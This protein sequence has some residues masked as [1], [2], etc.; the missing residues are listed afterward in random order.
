MERER[1]KEEPASKESEQSV[2]QRKKR[3][4]LVEEIRMFTKPTSRIRSMSCHRY[5]HSHSHTLHATPRTVHVFL[6]LRSQL[7]SLIH[8]HL[9]WHPSS[10]CC[11]APPSPRSSRLLCFSSPPAAS[12][13]SSE[14]TQLVALVVP[15][16]GKALA[17]RHRRRHC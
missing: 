12:S 9:R 6:L 15:L 1:D 14:L 7:G 11:S 5:P 3:S 4:E 16:L 8:R 2:E 10:S 13:Y 17:E